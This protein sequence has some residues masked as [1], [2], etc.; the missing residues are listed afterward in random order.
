MNLQI[1]SPIGYLS[2]LL[3]LLVLALWIAHVVKRPRRWWCHLALVAGVLSLICAK[4]NSESYVNRIQIDQSEEIAAAQ[5]RQAAA[6][7]AAEA[8]RGEDVA[9]IRFAED[10]AE[11][12]LD[13]AGMDEADKKYLESAGKPKD[14]AAAPEAPAWKTGKKQR[15]GPQ[16]DDSLEGMLNP[17]EQNKEAGALDE[18]VESQ[19]FAEPIV[20]SATDHYVANRLD[21]LNLK[22]IKI[23]LL[24]GMVFVVVDY[25]RRLNVYGEAYFPLP[26]PSAI[27]NS[28]TPMPAAWSRPVPPRRSMPQE[29]AWLSRRGDPFI[30]LTDNPKSAAKIPRK[31]ARLPFNLGRIDVLRANQESPLI[32]DAFVFEGAWFNR[33]C[34]VIDSAARAERFLQHL[35]D[36]LRDRR[37]TRAR[38]RQTVH[39]VWDMTTPIPEDQRDEL[40]KLAEATGIALLTTPTENQ[41]SDRSDRSGRSKKDHHAS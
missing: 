16:A 21:S 24:L 30:Y 9:Q 15:S 10:D 11:D 5:A 38:A 13:K 41:G 1:F 6:R 17:E 36:K 33:A 14:A 26:V 3:W 34:F 18:L 20:M 4:I 32:D 40:L 27:V 7:Q 12:F 37:E 23:L 2:V 28:M 29:L 31:T 19:N 25:L 35:V 39:M 8:A 22:W